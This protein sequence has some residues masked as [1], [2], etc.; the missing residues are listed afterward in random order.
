VAR[1]VAVLP[2]GTPGPTILR[3]RVA[4]VG[5]GLLQV[6]ARQGMVT[7]TIAAMTHIYVPNVNNPAPSNIRVGE[8]V[9]VIG[10]RTG[11]RRIEARFLA[12]LP[13]M[14]AHRFIISGE[15]TGIEGTSLTVQ[16]PKDAHTILID[17]QTRYHVPGVEQPTL[18][19][20]QVGDH[21]LALGQP[22]EGKSLL[23]RVIIVRRAPEPSPKQSELDI[24]NLPTPL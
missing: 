8:W 13:P 12:L 3:G 20:I 2:E 4:R 21:I 9:L 24:T 10:H 11:P 14:S 16:D 15:V 7:V 19:D 23:A 5:P 6:N 1:M 17:E 22:A 18:A